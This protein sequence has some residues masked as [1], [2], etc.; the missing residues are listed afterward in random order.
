MRWA[1]ALTAAGFA[2]LLG[3]VYA[4]LADLPDAVPLVLLG[5]APVVAF[6][7][8]RRKRTRLGACAM[9]LLAATAAGTG[10]WMA[11]LAPYPPGTKGVA[12]I[13]EPAPTAPSGREPVRV[14]DGARFHLRAQ[15][16]EDLL[17]V[18]FR[19]AW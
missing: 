3:P 19:G 18:F 9:V 4:R 13:G 6:L 12:A 17:I 14:R 2:A 8:W 5:A 7:A 10:V 1:F 16:R 11:W 15:R